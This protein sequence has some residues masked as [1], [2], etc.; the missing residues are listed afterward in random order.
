MPKVKLQISIINN[1]NIVFTI[2]QAL[3]VG[4]FDTQPN[5]YVNY[6]SQIKLFFQVPRCAIHQEFHKTGQEPARNGQINIDTE[7]GNPIKI[8]T[9][10]K[11]D[12]SSTY[13]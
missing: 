5:F 13:S 1:Q 12:C 4:R 11:T 10:I 7:C 8:R 6:L 9:N 2:L 3:S